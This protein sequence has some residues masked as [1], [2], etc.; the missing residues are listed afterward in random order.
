MSQHGSSG[1]GSAAGQARQNQAAARPDARHAGDPLRG[2]VAAD[3]SRASDTIRRW[4]LWLFL[5]ASAVLLWM[6]WFWT[7]DWQG[8]PDVTAPFTRK[9]IYFHPASAWASFAAYFTVFAYSVAYLNER[10]IRYDRPARAA[11]EVGFGFNTVA[12]ITGTVWGVQEWSRTGQ[13]SLATVYSEPKVLVVVVMWFTFAAYL[14]LRRFVDAPE[15]RARLSAVFG[16]MGFIT[17]PIAF[18]T[19]RVLQTSL[20]PDIGGPGKNPDA[21]VGASIG[22]AIGWSMVV[23]LLLFL[24]LWLQRDRILG[25]RDRVATL[26]DHAF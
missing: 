18:A 3:D 14:L 6:V 4:S 5:A 22:M 10:N 15:Q 25:L 8:E 21:A 1:G 24:H 7:P 2:A 12:L 17:V 23:F 11:A 19:S 20:H 26:E 16:V 9:L 13:S